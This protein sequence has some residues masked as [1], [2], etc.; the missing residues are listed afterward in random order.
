M[1]PTVGV[2][3]PDEVYKRLWDQAEKDG[4]TPAIEAAGI[5]EGQLKA[6]KRS[7]A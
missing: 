5:I 4:V 7:K 6:A 3:L 2:Y 1:M